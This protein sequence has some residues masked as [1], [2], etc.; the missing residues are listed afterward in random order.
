MYSWQDITLAVVS[1]I[2][3]VSLIPQAVLG[4]SKKIGVMSLWTSVPTTFG[5]AIIAYTYTTL[6]LYFSAGTTT[7]T[8]ILWLIFWVQRIKYRG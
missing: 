3:T 4:F 5:L 8:C 1:I 2:F 6:G 7:A